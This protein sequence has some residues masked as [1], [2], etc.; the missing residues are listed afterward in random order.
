MSGGDHPVRPAGEA[1]RLVRLVDALIA[2]CAGL[3]LIA[4]AIAALVS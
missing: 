2:G 4:I 3:V 1:G